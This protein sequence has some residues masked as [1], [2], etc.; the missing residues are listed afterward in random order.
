[1]GSIK[2]IY[3]QRTQ[4]LMLCF[5]DISQLAAAF[6][7]P[8]VDRHL[9]MAQTS[10]T[11]IPNVHTKKISNYCEQGKIW[12]GGVQ[13]FTEMLR[14][15]RRRKN[16]LLLYDAVQTDTILLCSTRMWCS[17]LQIILNIITFHRARPVAESQ[18]H[19]KFYVATCSKSPLAFFLV[20]SHSYIYSMSL[21]FLYTN[22]CTFCI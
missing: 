18:M 14:N 5:A 13:E 22:K 11:E 15:Q 2:E 10:S 6:V 3:P 21:F 20:S 19:L 8:C 7:L 1:M 12:G 17:N 16:V 9:V 4:Q